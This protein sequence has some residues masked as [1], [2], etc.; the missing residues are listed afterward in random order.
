ME[1]TK[2]KRFSR[3][4]AHGRGR[5]FKTFPIE[6]FVF[7]ERHIGVFVYWL[8]AACSTY[9][10]RQKKKKKVWFHLS[11]FSLAKS[12]E[13][14]SRLAS[15][16]DTWTA[17]ERVEGAVSGQFEGSSIEQTSRL[18]KLQCSS[19]GISKHIFWLLN[20]AQ[21]RSVPL[22]NDNYNKRS[23]LIIRLT[24]AITFSLYVS[25]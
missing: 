17:S 14:T 23:S 2:K 21:A 7:F 16:N 13:F 8:P 9:M 5:A 20:D 18:T 6:T 3:K 1:R 4:Q 25:N 11:R 10:S 24:L 12:V 15:S 22:V 19:N